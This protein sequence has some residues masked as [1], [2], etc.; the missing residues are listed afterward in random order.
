MQISTYE[1]CFLSSTFVLM[2]KLKN[3]RKSTSPQQPTRKGKSKYQE[4]DCM[5]CKI[6]I[7]LIISYHV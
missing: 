5:V 4:C 3:S 2:S 7:L 6:G 1:D